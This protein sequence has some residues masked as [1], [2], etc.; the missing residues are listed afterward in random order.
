[1]NS[2][3]DLIANVYEYFL[4][5]YG[6]ATPN[7]PGGEILA[8]EPMGFSP[9]CSTLADGAALSMSQQ[10]VSLFADVLPVLD[11]GTFRHTGRTV[12]VQYSLLLEAAQPTSSAS[13]DSFS[14]LKKQAKEAY[15]NA[16]SDGELG[17]PKLTGA[18]PV[19][20]Y[21]VTKAAN[22]NTYNYDSSQAGPAQPAAPRAPNVHVVWRV[23]PLQASVA[24]RP[25]VQAPVEHGIPITVAHPGFM[26]AP[27]ANTMMVNHAAAPAPAMVPSAFVSV[28]R[29]QFNSRASVA[30]VAAQTA[31]QPVATTKFT[32]SF[33]YC[34]VRLRRSWLSGD[35]L[36]AAGWY[37]PGKAAGD[38]TAGGQ[39][40]TGGFAVVPTAFIAVKNLNINAALPAGV[41]ADA[42][43]AA[44][45]GPF[46]LLG[47][48]PNQQGALV[49]PG[50]QVIAWICSVQPA[51]PPDAD[52][53]LPTLGGAVSTAISGNGTDKNNAAGTALGDAINAATGAAPQKDQA[54]INATVNSS[55]GAVNEVRNLFAAF[56]HGDQTK[57]SN[58]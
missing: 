15:D 39:L 6:Q 49:D 4:K 53:S 37:V 34:L 52:P 42:G 35:F 7:G 8:F 21:D 5:A 54:V 43:S 45:F 40:N 44:A 1:M 31:P 38:C 24:Q 55:V 33:D 23:L 2:N 29:N 13:I 22:W 28:H 11:G 32:I 9:S 16:P 20:W 14:A 36:T 10:E 58:G 27:A 47:S 46:S 12:S 30:A 18:T 48:S 51:L 26:A 56:G 25:A 41:T 19:D 57:D 17:G 50:L 3:D